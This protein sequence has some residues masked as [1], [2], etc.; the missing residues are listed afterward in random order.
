VAIES[1]FRAS[2]LGSLTPESFALGTVPPTITTEACYSKR[3]RLDV[4]PVRRDLAE[5][6]RPW[7]AGK[8]AGKPVFVGDLSRA[9]EM[10]KADLG[11]AGITYGT[12]EG[13][14][15]FHC[16]RVC[17][18]TRLVASGASVKVCQELA[19]H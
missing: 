16:L 17:Y 4:Q 7:L 5:L 19:R 1:G 3:R 14:A 18:I 10:M 9:A 8:E 15:D 6:L 11:A 12:P 2:E 13:L